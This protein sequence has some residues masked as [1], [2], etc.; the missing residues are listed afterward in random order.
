MFL[1]HQL[2]SPT[3]GSGPLCSLNF[4]ISTYT[5]EPFDPQ[6]SKLAE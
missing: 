3:H 1:G 4:K 5:P 2:L 6:W